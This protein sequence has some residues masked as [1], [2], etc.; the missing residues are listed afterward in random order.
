M[1]G[2]GSAMSQPFLALLADRTQAPQQEIHVLGQHVGVVLGKDPHADGVAGSHVAR[3]VGKGLGRVIATG[4]EYLVVDHRPAE[5][6]NGRHP[7][8]SVRSQVALGSG[9]IVGW[10]TRARR[11]IVV[12]DHIEVEVHVLLR[13]NKV[14]GHVACNAHRNAR[15]PDG[16]GEGLDLM[17]APIGDAL[18]NH[19]ADSENVAQN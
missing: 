18:V 6:P 9:R 5:S 10:R 12:R 11:R 15:C 8:L 4:G 14:D 2:A 19:T 16:L 1:S 3:C 13:P 17:V 7:F